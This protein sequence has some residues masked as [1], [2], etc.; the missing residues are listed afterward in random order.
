MYLN[1]QVKGTPPLMKAFL[2]RNKDHFTYLGLMMI[3]LGLPLS[4]A[5]MSIGIFVLVLVAL[6]QQNFKQ[7]FIQFFTITPFLA[8]V[9][10][11][12][13]VVISGLWSSDTP[14]YFKAVRIKLPF[15]LLPISLFVLLPIQQKGFVIVLKTYLWIIVLSSLWSLFYLFMNF[16]EITASYGYGK[17]LITP[18]NHIRFSLMVVMAI[19]VG[20]YLLKQKIIDLPWKK[21]ITIIAIFY[22]VVFLHLLAVRSGLLAF[23]TIALILTL[24]YV[25]E[26]KS[27]MVLGLMTISLAAV[28]T[29]GVNFSPTLNMKYRYMKYEL[30]NYFSGNYNIVG[31]DGRRLLSIRSG[32]EVGN[33]NKLLGVGYGDVKKATHSMYSL[34]F[35]DIPEE[36]K[37]LPHNQWVY[38]YAGLGLTG[39]LLFIV[40]FFLPLFYR[41]AWKNVLVLG[42]SVITFTSFFSEYTF[43]TQVGVTFY[44]FFLLVPFCIHLHESKLKMSN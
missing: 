3:V 15:L 36:N 8:I 40:S 35:P 12:F 18:T 32:I 7:R 42:I 6:F 9:A 43:E 27:Y 33:N 21:S 28:I 10:F 30:E 34:L 37:K 41:D 38:I 16:S 17:V 14:A 5:M 1:F 31:S 26:T 19:I 13:L 2:Q 20:Y 4:R 23:Y 24:L 25:V 39:L 44:T 22:L 29:L 11:Y